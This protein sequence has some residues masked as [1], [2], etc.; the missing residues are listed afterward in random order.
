MTK[1]AMR[2]VPIFVF[3]FSS[4]VFLLIDQGNHRIH[5]QSEGKPVRLPGLEN[6]IQ[7]NSRL[8][9]GSSPEGDA[10]FVT[11]D[12]LGIKTIL[13]VDG[14]PPD[15][16]RAAKFGLRYVHLPIRYDGI[17]QDQAQRLA[18]AA[19]EL[20]GPIYLHCHHGKHR[21]PAAA[22]AIQY[23]LNTKCSAAQ[24]VAVM[25]RAGTDPRYTGLLSAPNMLKRLNHAELAKLKIEFHQHEKITLLAESM[26][27]IDDHW[28]NLKRIRL[29][30]WATPQ[31]HPD[32]DPAH[33][34]LQLLELYRE[35]ERSPEVEARAGDFSTKLNH[36]KN[37]AADLE[38][39][40]RSTERQ[41][42]KSN[43]NAESAF[44]R[45]RLACTQCHAA[46]R[47]IPQAAK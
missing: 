10:G 46:Y 31:G 4:S 13:S 33:E 40:L 3:G 39:A 26:V 44:Q 16:S 11:L 37:A 15:V 42:Q 18:K 34:A 27:Q 25:T 20:P 41:K 7:V 8:I 35:L 30:G 36:A 32:L 6:V 22:A 21:A 23:C 12:K 2:I 43:V 24:A 29:A 47:D 19:L 14:M 28:E 45:S 1:F 5:L 38:A 9:S 17:S